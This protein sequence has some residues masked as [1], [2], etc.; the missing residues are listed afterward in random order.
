MNLS[1]AGDGM[2]KKYTEILKVYFRDSLIKTRNVKDL[3]QSQMAEIL[4]MD[5]RSY[6]DLNN[7][8]SCCSALTLALYLIFFVMILT[9][10]SMDCESDSKR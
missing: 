3:T 10:L 2:R 9:N 6:A 7:G 4:I 5:N 1:K 8:K